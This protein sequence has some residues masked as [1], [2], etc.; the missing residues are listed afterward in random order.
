M[1]Y[2]RKS[3]HC[4]E[5]LSIYSSQKQFFVVKTTGVRGP[6]LAQFDSV[7]ELLFEGRTS[8]SRSYLRARPH[9]G[10]LSCDFSI[11]L[12]W[13]ISCSMSYNGNERLTV[14]LVSAESLFRALF[15]GNPEHY[16]SLEAGEKPS[17]RSPPEGLVELICHGISIRI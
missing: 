12:H 10:Q 1:H 5:H 4:F 14:N 8:C 15:G 7:L 6:T 3:C 13:K 9:S 2:L 11:T 16:E 17:S